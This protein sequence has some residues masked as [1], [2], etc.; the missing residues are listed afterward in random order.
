VNFLN[1]GNNTNKALLA[2]IWHSEVEPWQRSESGG[3]GGKFK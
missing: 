1:F 2:Q 3:S